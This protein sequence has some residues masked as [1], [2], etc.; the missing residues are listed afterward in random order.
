MKNPSINLLPRYLGIVINVQVSSS[1]HASNATVE[2][3]AIAPEL[4]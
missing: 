2:A 4:L 3:H 1:Y